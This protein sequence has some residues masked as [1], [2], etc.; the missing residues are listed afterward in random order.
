MGVWRLG[1]WLSEWP[2]IYFWLLRHFGT[3]SCSMEC[4]EATTITRSSVEAQYRSIPLAAVEP[5]WITSLLGELGLSS[6]KP[7]LW[8]DNLGA[9]F[10]VAD[11]V[12]QAQTKHIEIDIH[13]VRD[14]VAKKSL[15]IR[16]ISTTEQIANVMTKA[17]VSTVFHQLH[18]KLTF[19][20]PV[21][22]S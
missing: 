8:C 19:V 3:K 6:I 22:L 17:L 15:F 4:Q 12:S 21:S 5:C 16:R 13:F 1:C 10:L 9:T 18:D 7:T 2:S 20:L 14:L 11:L